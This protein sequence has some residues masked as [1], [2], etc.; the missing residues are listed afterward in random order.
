MVRSLR[1]GL[2]TPTP[3]PITIK[4]NRRGGSLLEPSEGA[5]EL[6]H[7]SACINGWKSWLLDILI[8]HYFAQFMGC[9]IGR[10]HVGLNTSRPKQNGRDFADDIFKCIFLMIIYEFRLRFHGSL[11]PRFEST[12]FRHWGR[13]WPAADQ[14]TSHYLNQWC[15]VYWRVYASLGLNGLRSYSVL[16]ILLSP[17]IIMMHDGSR[18]LSTCKCM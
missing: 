18:A 1:Q 16:D 8:S 4:Q 14:A 3:G 5:F 10:M 17:T 13:Y 7:G 15:L 6:T 2:C 11:F 12:I 9:V